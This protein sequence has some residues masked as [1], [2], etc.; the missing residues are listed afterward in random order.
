MD[1]LVSSFFKYK[2]FWLE[3]LWWAKIVL[4]FGIKVLKW[5]CHF[6]NAFSSWRY[7]LS[8][9]YKFFLSNFWKWVFIDERN[10]FFENMGY[11]WVIYKKL[12]FSLALRMLLLAY[13]LHRKTCKS[14]TSSVTAWKHTK[15]IAKIPI[16]KIGH[17]KVVN[18]LEPFRWLMHLYL[19]F[20]I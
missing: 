2:E 5:V 1:I 3:K 17:A 8:V 9:F 4:D 13:A 12:T 7:T 14:S 6:W 19:L 18:T 20:A 11:P 10:F 16:Q 15:I